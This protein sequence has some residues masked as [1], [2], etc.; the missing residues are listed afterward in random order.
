M[1][2]CCGKPTVWNDMCEDCLY[3]YTESMYREE[4]ERLYK[5][6]KVKDEVMTKEEALGIV[7]DLAS[8]NVL[9]FNDCDLDPSLLLQAAR[10]HKALNIV[11]KL[12]DELA[13]GTIF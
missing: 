3:E 7:Y 8:E 12:M 6:S 2:T 9:G 11:N 5:E 13:N 10:Q 1:G 4:D